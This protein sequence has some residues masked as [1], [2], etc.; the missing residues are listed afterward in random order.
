MAKSHRT[1]GTSD[2]TS[3]TS[4]TV[5]FAPGDLPPEASIPA[6]PEPFTALTPAD[7]Q[8]LLKIPADQAA[9]VDQAM[10]ELGAKGAQLQADLGTLAPSIEEGKK[11]FERMLLARAANAKAQAL[12]AYTDEQEA[13]ANHAVMGYLNEVVGDIEHVSTKKPQIVTHYP[14][15]VLVFEQRRQAIV[16]GIARA[17]AA[18]SDPKNEPK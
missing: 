9:E 14:K 15:A 16:D 4:P 5:T 7:K 6:V 10:I 1:S 13:L 8:A 12:A 18:K 3:G 2:A 17:K 11:R